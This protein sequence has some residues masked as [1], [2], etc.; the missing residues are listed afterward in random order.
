MAIAAID[1]AVVAAGIDRAFVDDI[2]AAMV[3]AAAI[4][5][6][7]SLFE[8]AFLV[9]GAELFVLTNCLSNVL[10]QQRRAMRE[11]LRL[12]VF[13]DHFEARFRRH[14]TIGRGQDMEAARRRPGFRA[15]RLFGRRTTLA[16]AGALHVV[17]RHRDV[18]PFGDF[19]VGGRIV[20]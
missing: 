4:P 5:F 8:L 17:Q 15:R 19:S 18:T 1:R 11:R 6:E 9:L 7:L 10:A 14:V 16:D 12:A 2:A 20:V 3:A 13:H